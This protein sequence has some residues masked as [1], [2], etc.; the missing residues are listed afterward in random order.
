MKLKITSFIFI[1]LGTYWFLAFLGKKI[2]REIFP[3][4]H[5]SLYAQI[6]NNPQSYHLEVIKINGDNL[7]KPMTFYGITKELLEF[8]RAEFLLRKAVTTKSDS[9]LLNV[10]HF[11]PECSES[12][13]FV[14]QAN[15]KKTISF[16]SKYE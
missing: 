8:R 16:L 4:F 9:D 12:E 7:S 2:G 11:L 15:S 3:F 6:P 10:L 14:M 1:L 13:L 5:W